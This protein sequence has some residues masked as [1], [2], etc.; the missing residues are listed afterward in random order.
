MHKKDAIRALC[1][2]VVV[3]KI[4]R[5]SFVWITCLPACHA[6]VIG[7]LVNTFLFRDPEVEPENDGDGDYAGIRIVFAFTSTRMTFVM[8]CC[9]LFP[10]N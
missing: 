2:A 7:F 5:E 1:C 4:T 10:L 8:F 9:V 3:V 6:P